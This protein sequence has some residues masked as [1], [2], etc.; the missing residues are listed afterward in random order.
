[1]VR[2]PRI[3]GTVRL[4]MV[5]ASIGILIGCAP[6]PPTARVVQAP[7]EGPFSVTCFKDEEVVFEHPEIYR[8]MAP[9]GWTYETNEGVTFRG[10]LGSQVNC[11]WARDPNAKRQ[12]DPAEGYKDATVSSR[13]NTA[14]F[15]KLDLTSLQN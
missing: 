2:L 13:S 14:P 9:T 12:D 8:T 1:M 15:L 10:R 6:P 11:Q 5:G 4:G 3:A 7:R